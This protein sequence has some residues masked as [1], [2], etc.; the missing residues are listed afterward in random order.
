MLREFQ[1]RRKL[2]RGSSACCFLQNDGNFLQE[3]VESRGF[4][5]YETEMEIVLW[6]DG[7]R[8]GAGTRF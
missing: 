1:E 7:R 3:V 5:R 2:R 4:G 6:W 8:E